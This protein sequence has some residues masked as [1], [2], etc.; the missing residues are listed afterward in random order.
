M[1]KQHFP[2]VV[3]SSGI[4]PFLAPRL[5]PVS[6][7]SSAKGSVIF[8]TV[9]DGGLMSL[10][11][12]IEFVVVKQGNLAPS[13]RSCWLKLAAGS[14]VVFKGG[15]ERG[16]GLT[17]APP[18]MAPANTPSPSGWGNQALL[19]QESRSTCGSCR[20]SCAPVL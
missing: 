20:G 16:C 6:Y 3:I 15:K 17:G 1:S 10:Y 13:L 7:H 5:D 11:L 4:K 9:P 2:V 12:K 8:G 14:E 19:K 18:A